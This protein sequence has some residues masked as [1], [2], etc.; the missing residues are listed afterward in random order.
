MAL[1]LIRGR[2]DGRTSRHA[3]GPE[4]WRVVILVL[5]ILAEAFPGK[6][7]LG[8]RWTWVCDKDGMC[9]RIATTWI[10]QRVGGFFEALFEN[11][12]IMAQGLLAGQ[13]QQQR[14]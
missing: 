2:A 14:T 5:A 6:G 13:I 10:E 1:K 4:Q 9:R 3:H 7:T 11:R 8:A 12:V